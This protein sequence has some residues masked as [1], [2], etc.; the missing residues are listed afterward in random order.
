MIAAA[1]EQQIEPRRQSS[2]GA[3]KHCKQHA[4]TTDDREE[5]QRSLGLD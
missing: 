4:M 3:G 2:F 5:R 1:A